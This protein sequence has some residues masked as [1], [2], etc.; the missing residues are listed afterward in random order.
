MSEAH[1]SPE[2]EMFEALESNR[3]LKCLG[4][5]LAADREG[6]LKVSEIL[7]GFDFGAEV[8]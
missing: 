2:L 6:V 4:R 7:D 3:K 5:K 1:A 8:K